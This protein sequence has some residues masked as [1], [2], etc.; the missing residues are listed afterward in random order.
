MALSHVLHSSFLDYLQGKL[1]GGFT[2]FSEEMHALMLRGSLATMYRGL[3][4]N[5]CELESSFLLNK[6]VPNLRDRISKHVTE[7]LQYAA[8][9][10]VFHLKQ[11]NVEAKGSAEK[12]V[13]F[14]DSVKGLYWV[15]VLSLM[16]AVDRGIV[17]LQDCASF[18]TVRPFARDVMQQLTVSRMNRAL[19]R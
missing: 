10:W 11:A 8:T 18:F 17:M 4:F 13:A 19:W 2:E 7:A 12:V 6:D 16:D 9:F 5:I 14:L 15:E 3:K 1:E